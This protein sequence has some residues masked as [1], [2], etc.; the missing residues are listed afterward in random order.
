MQ[1]LWHFYGKDVNYFKNFNG[2]LDS[3]NAFFEL[4]LVGLKCLG[5]IMIQDLHLEEQKNHFK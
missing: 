2:P 3:L 4:I 5:L 1:L